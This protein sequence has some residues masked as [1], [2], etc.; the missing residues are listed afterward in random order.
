[1]HIRDDITEVNKA[2]HGPLVEERRL[3]LGAFPGGFLAQLTA[4]GCMPPIILRRRT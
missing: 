2:E 1:M 3:G 4:L